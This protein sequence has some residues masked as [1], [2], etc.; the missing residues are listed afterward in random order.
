MTQT[1]SRRDFTR[2]SA[3]A[4]GGLLIAVRVPGTNGLRGI[5]NAMAASADPFAPNAWIRL[6][7]DGIVT[8]VVDRSEMGQGV[9]TSLPVLIAEEMDADW[10]KIRV[11]HAPVD[12]IYN[13][14]LFGMQATGGSSSVRSSWQH[15][16]EA[17]AAAREMLVGAA[18]ERLNVDA[19]TLTTS[20]GVVAHAATGR[21]LR[22]GELATA[23]AARAVPKTPRLKDPKDFKLIGTRVKRLDTPAKVNG[24]ATFGIDVRVPGMLVAVVARP[25]VFGAKY[26]KHDD[27][28]ARAI[29]G[30]KRIVPITSGVAVIADS[31]WTASKA[32]KALNVTWDTATNV[33]RSSATIAQQM[34]DAAK[35][36]GVVAKRE[37]AGAD[38]L[39]HAS[40]KLEAEYTVP[41]LAHAAMEPMNA[42][43]DVRA[44]GCDIWAPTQ[45]QDETRAVAARITGLTPDRINVQTTYLGGGFGRKFET[46]FIIDAV[47]ASKA[48]GAPV[49]MIFSREDDIQH[50]F[51]R[52]AAYNKLAA[53]V[54]GFILRHAVLHDPEARVADDFLVE[55]TFTRR[56]R[57]AVDELAK[58][59]RDGTR[60]R[61][62]EGHDAW[63]G[64]TRGRIA[65]G[66]IRD[67][68]FGE[69]RRGQ[70]HESEDT[71]NH[72][73]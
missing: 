36:P 11:E 49:K 4:S 12:P 46:D 2:A 71:A 28:A 47:E 30:V 6:A 54:D 40:R 19:A 58:R 66:L 25:A 16:R 53:S 20:N 7:P 61:F 42:V 24:S 1:T 35:Q 56:S 50:D 3:I 57:V 10:S 64:R 27:T 31:Y 15:F 32:R 69:G 14:A 38:A 17:G 41:F 63:I 34:R 62:I 65:F 18:A 29:D 52:T 8:V 45:R 33:N 9:D 37:G 44:D 68:V 60:K 23:A 26:V 21:S 67:D 22:Y 39:A 70:Q 13:N 43:A 73:R 51:Y 72:G 55:L 5:A 48:A 59:G